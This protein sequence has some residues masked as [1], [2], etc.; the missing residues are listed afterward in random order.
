MRDGT[1]IRRQREVT[2]KIEKGETKEQARRYI[3][4]LTGCVHDTSEINGT[5]P[6]RGR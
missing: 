4:N 3:S 6:L 5:E 1:E 2:M